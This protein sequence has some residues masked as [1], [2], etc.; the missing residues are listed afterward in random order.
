MSVLFTGLSHKLNS[1]LWIGPMVPS[2]FAS[3]GSKW[4][5]MRKEVLAVLE[6]NYYS[7]AGQSV[8]KAVKLVPNLK[9]KAL[10]WLD[11]KSGDL[12][13]SPIV[14]SQGLR[15]SLVGREG[16]VWKS[17]RRVGKK[18]GKKGWQDPKN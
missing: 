9:G 17:M 1:N 16:L 8:W 6:K 12:G 18:V 7:E 10:A 5:L 4:S 14:Q 11:R 13:N 3:W 15:I 2:F